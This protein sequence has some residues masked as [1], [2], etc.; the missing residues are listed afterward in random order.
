MYQLVKPYHWKSIC[1]REP[2][3]PSNKK[4]LLLIKNGITKKNNYLVYQF[5]NFVYY[6]VVLLPH[7]KRNMSLIPKNGLFPRKP[8]LDLTP[9]I[10]LK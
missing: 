4:L 5:T 6:P 7:N 8:H 10:S 9:L 3:M 2:E 1:T